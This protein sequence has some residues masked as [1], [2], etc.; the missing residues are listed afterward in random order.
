MALTIVDRF[1][2]TSGYSTD[3]DA[4]DYISADA[5][6]STFAPSGELL[7]ESLCE[8]TISVVWTGSAGSTSGDLIDD[9][10][11]SEFAAYNADLH[12]DRV[13]TNPETG[14]MENRH[15]ETAIRLCEAK[16]GIMVDGEV[17]LPA[18]LDEYKAYGHGFGVDNTATSV[19][20]Y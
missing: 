20:K 16:Y 12:F 10:I 4:S 3:S 14:E 7:L 15:W 11:I 18:Y 17:I 13:H 19:K 2:S 9:W 6:T 5:I 1:Y 8:V